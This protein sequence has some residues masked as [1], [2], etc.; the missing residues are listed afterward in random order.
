MKKLLKNYDNIFNS[1][2][3]NG[4]ASLGAPDPYIYKYN[5]SY[6]LICTRPKGLVLMQSDNLINW[7]YVNEDGIVSDDKN[8]VAAYAPELTYYDGYFYITASPLGNGHYIWRSK[9]IT[10]PYVL[11]KDK[12]DE[13]IDGSFFVDSDENR[14]FLRATETG[15]ASKKFKTDNSVTDFNLFDD[16]YFYFDNTIIGNWT[17]GPF[18]LKRYG[19]Y[20]LTYTGTHFLSDAYRVDYASG[21]SYKKDGLSF[22]DTTLLS[23]TDEFYGLGHSMTFLGPDLDSYYIAFHNML[24]S[25]NRFLNISRLVFD[26]YQ[27]MMVNG[28][29]VKNNPIFNRPYF[30]KKIASPNYL[31]D[32]IFEN[33]Q[34]SI[35]YNFKGKNV[36][37]YLSYKDDSNY[38][39]IKLNNNL[40]IINCV[41]GIENV[42]YELPL[43]YLGNP[44]VFHSI[45]L[46][47]TNSKI[48]IYLDNVEIIHNLKLKINKGK[49]GFINNEM[50]CSY[51]AYSLE[52]HGSS[53]KKI[54]KNNEFY[55]SNCEKENNTYKTVFNVNEDAEYMLYLHSTKQTKLSDILVN[56]V[57]VDDITSTQDNTIITKLQLNKGIHNISFKCNKIS[58]NLKIKIV[59]NEEVNNITLDNLV[60]CS[61]VYWNYK[62]LPTGIYLENDRNAIIT[63]NKYTNFEL[64][65]KIKLVG[66]PTIKD[67]FIGL[68]ACCNNYSKTNN[69]ENG[70][71]LMGYLFVLDRNY[72]YIIDTNFYH[73]KILKKIPLNNLREMELKI[74]KTENQI[75]FYIEN[76]M[77]Y[78]IENSNKY[79]SGNCGIYNYHVSGIFKSFKL[80][81]I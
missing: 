54:V 49:I 16:D 63:K 1:K 11:Y 31:S 42:G 24:K 13:L 25:G 47:C 77:V 80:N 36:K 28:A 64:S 46:Q 58:N 21:R 75:S 22:K 15:I 6:Y 33:K 2:K 60:D 17:E 72:A 37:L 56:D 39:F 41:N 66:N 19:T 69:F 65:S 30:E 45:R 8:I 57:R 20:Y 27:N 18:M 34:F 43:K 10:G 78:K 48:T 61:N 44:A 55:I 76:N 81:K 26:E 23:T 35:E 38:Q 5:G 53:D 14:Y 32:E 40:Q 59:K 68:I 51:L 12:F 50:N 70:Y 74:I 3:I 9:D 29:Y 4:V 62:K 71:S 52:A 7:E 73:S 79:I 67:R